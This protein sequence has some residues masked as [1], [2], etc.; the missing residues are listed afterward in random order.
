VGFAHVSGRPMMAIS[1][2]FFLGR[3][4][5]HRVSPAACFQ[6]LVQQIVH[7]QWPCLRSNR[8]TP[9]TPREIK[10]FAAFCFLHRGI[11]LVSRRPT[12]G[13]SR[14][15]AEV[16]ASSWSSG[17]K[18]RLAVYHPAPS[19]AAFF[20]RHARLAKNSPWGISALSVRHN[21]GRCPQLPVPGPVSIRSCRT[22]GH[23]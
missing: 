21:A 23:G 14:A 16:R 19:R 1:T 15:C 5:L 7:A 11:D 9:E 22:C 8:K 17:V 18:T 3:L 20:E 2:S 12:N 4:V 13:F 10:R 6:R